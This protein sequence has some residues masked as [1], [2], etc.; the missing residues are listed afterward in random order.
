MVGL[1]NACVQNSAD[2]SAIPAMGINYGLVAGWQ[3]AALAFACFA[4]SGLP[5]V[6]EY[7]SRIHALRKHDQDQADKL[8][9]ELLR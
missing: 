2:G 6:L 3:A 8:A 7:V 4:A 1:L 9:K 5:M